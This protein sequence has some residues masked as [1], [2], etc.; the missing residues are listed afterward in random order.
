[1]SK[2]ISLC[3]HWR[4]MTDYDVEYGEDFE[5]LIVNMNILGS[6]YQVKLRYEVFKH[7]DG[8]NE[9]ILHKNV[10]DFCAISSLAENPYDWRLYEYI[11]QMF[12]FPYDPE[13]LSQAFMEWRWENETET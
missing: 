7:L 13:G 2:I 5:Y 11:I 8:C 12:K 6:S 1:M 3:G 4:N 9:I 10:L